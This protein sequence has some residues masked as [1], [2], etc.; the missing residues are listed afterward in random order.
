VTAVLPL[1]FTRLMWIWIAIIG[2]AV[3]GEMPDVLACVGSAGIFSSAS[4]IAF[5]EIRTKPPPR[6][7]AKTEALGNHGW[8]AARPA[9]APGEKT[10]DGRDAKGQ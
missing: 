5:R 1:N 8:D 7:L 4:Y 3:F 10:H 9:P 6:F 2:Y